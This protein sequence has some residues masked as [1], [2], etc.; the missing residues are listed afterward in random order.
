MFQSAFFFGLQFGLAL[1]LDV[2]SV[3]FFEGLDVF[4]LPLL[5]PL[6][7]QLATGS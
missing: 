4:K 7:I 1:L 2:L 5:I 6:R 3:S